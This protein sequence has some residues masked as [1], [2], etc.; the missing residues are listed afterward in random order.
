L[1]VPLALPITT[2]TSFVLA[3]RDTHRAYNWQSRAPPRA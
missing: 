1:P 3:L 2:A